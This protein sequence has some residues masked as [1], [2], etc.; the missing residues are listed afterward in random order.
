MNCD[1]AFELITH[2][3]DHNCD[4]L[5]WHLQMCPRCQQM[6]ETLAPALT[7]FQQLS[8]EIALS[9]EELALFDA[10]FTNESD[11]QPSSGYAQ[12]GK[13]FLSPEAVRIAEQTATRLS[14]EAGI[15]KPATQSTPVPVQRKRLLQAALILLVG[16]ALGWGISMEVPET[17]LPIGAASPSGQQPCLWIAQRDQNTTTPQKTER[18]SKAAVN[19]VVLSCVACHLQ[20]SAD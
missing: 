20:S 8:D 9:E 4:E 14:A 12:G 10:H 16:L 2:P 6:Q 13:P 3:T 7:S 19:S 11:P 1:E 18:S 5:Q 17:P 15:S